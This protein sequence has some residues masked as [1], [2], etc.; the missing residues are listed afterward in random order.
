ML[1][2]ATC[3]HTQASSC[4]FIC[5]VIYAGILGSRVLDASITEL[6]GALTPCAG[7]DGCVCVWDVRAGASTTPHL[8]HHWPAHPGSEI[9]TILHD[10]MKN[11]IITAGNDSS[12][13]VSARVHC[14]T[15]LYHCSCIQYLLFICYNK[16]LS[17]NYYITDDSPL[18]YC[19]FVKTKCNSTSKLI[20]RCSI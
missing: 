7:F 19:N 13:R 20:C 16:V 10:P 9:L 8:M 3:L 17:L 5:E 18:C 4:D 15:V 12:V 14:A 1:P 6:T 2:T 11:A